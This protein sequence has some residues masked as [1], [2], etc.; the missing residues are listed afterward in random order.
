MKY[1]KSNRVNMKKWP[2]FASN[3]VY[4]PDFDRSDNVVLWDI[5]EIREAELMEIEF[6]S[7]NSPYRQGVRIAIDRGEGDISVLNQTH[8]S[9]FLWFDTAPRKT[10]IICRNNE[11]LVSVYNVFDDGE[12]MHSH[13]YKSGMKIEEVGEKRIYY[14]NDFG[15]TEKFDKLIFSITK[16]GAHNNNDF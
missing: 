2:D 10:R 14:C 1:R 4:S 13:L 3:R 11:G 5:L 9:I 8:R 6:I 12:G 15:D 16:L 7:I